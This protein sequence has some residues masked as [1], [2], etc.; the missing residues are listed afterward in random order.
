MKTYLILFL[1]IVFE[2]SWIHQHGDSAQFPLR[3]DGGYFCLN[4]LAEEYSDFYFH[5]ITLKNDIFHFTGV[6][7]DGYEVSLDETEL[8]DNDLL[9]ICD[10]LINGYY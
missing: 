2:T 4:V 3:S 5:T 8:L 1:A 10:F 6:N 7:E 9:Y